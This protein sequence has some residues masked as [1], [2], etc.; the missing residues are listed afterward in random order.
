MSLRGKVQ[1]VE[2]LGSESFIY[3]ELSP[4]DSIVVRKSGHDIPKL[5]DTVGAGPLPGCGY[6]FD[7]DTRICIKSNIG[8][9]D[10]I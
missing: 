9:Q 10:D 5:G 8:N 6:F 4:E 1:L 7:A 2:H 3:V